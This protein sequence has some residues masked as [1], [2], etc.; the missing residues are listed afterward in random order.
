MLTAEV[1]GINSIKSYWNRAPVHFKNGFSTY[2]L[3]PD[4][5]ELI[6]RLSGGFLNGQW[7]PEV[8]ISINASR[9]NADLSHHQ[10]LSIDLARARDS[11]CSGFSLCFSDLSAKIEELHDL[12]TSAVSVFAF[13]DLIEVTAYLSPRHA[14]GVLHYDRQHNYFIQREG[15]KR[16]TVSLK[17]AA[18]NPHENFVYSGA[19]SSFFEEMNSSG[20]EI[21]L[22]KDCGRTTFDLMPGDIL[23]VPPGYYHSPETISEHSLHYTLTVEPACFWKDLQRELYRKLLASKGQ[24]YEDYRFMSEH[25]RLELF[26]NCRKSL[27]L[28]EATPQ[29]RQSPL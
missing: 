15:T 24:Y 29:G 17:A 6:S 22:P 4:A 20:Y 26:K 16:W 10:Y 19:R 1:F 8:K 23:Y 27:G 21:G 25:E 5:A 9:I 28:G 3:L 11:Y 13:A 18:S 12:K 14:V 7:R 2:E